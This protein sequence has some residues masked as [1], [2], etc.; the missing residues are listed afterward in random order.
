MTNSTLFCGTNQ[1]EVIY[2]SSMLNTGRTPATDLKLLLQNW[3]DTS[4]RV[5]VGGE[6][7]MVQSYCQVD[8]SELGNTEECQSLNPTQENQA[9]EE[10]DGASEALN[11][12][13]IGGGAAGG[14]VLIVV[15]F[16]VVG[17]VAYCSM[18]NTSSKGSF[19]W[20]KG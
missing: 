14:V 3:V 17:T 2:Q 9:Q 13:V 11:I 18:R 16:I 5:L 19:S 20:N 1:E 8:L 10:E 6:V 7:Q 12:T 4:P 15:L